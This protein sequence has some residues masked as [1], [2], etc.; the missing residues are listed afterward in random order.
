MT[1]ALGSFGGPPCPTLDGRTKNVNTTLPNGQG[2]SL[3]NSTI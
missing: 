3:T 2:L 1:E